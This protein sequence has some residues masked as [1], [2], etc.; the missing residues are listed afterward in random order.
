MGWRIVVKGN[1]HYFLG[2][3]WRYAELISA[4]C[5]VCQGGARQQWLADNS[6]MAGLSLEGKN[7][8]SLAM[9]RP[10]KGQEA[11]LEAAR[12]ALT[13]LPTPKSWMFLSGAFGSGKSHILVA[14]VNACLAAG[15]WARY[16]T[17][18][19]MLQ[20]LRSSYDPMTKRRYDDV[21]DEWT[22]VPALALDELDR[23]SVTDWVAEH[24][25][26]TLEARHTAGRATW[27]A[28][29]ASPDDLL[30]RGGPLG[31]IVSRASA[32]FVVALSTPDLRPAMQEELK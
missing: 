18:S 27:M 32:G 30:E 26:A 12:R 25:F 6:G 15:V 20:S 19:Q 28:S 1:R 10:A 3:V 17:A 9:P 5:P 21:F 23:V 16:A 29:N 11:A 24:L 22:S 4:P 2:D 13:E 8:L 7:M 14:M 31:A